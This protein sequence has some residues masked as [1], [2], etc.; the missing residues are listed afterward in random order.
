M[1]QYPGVVTWMESV[2]EYTKEHGYVETVWKRRRYLPG[3]YERNKN[4]FDLA[5]RVAINTVA[6]GT[7]AE[8]MK[9]GMV[10]L[11]RALKKHGLRA[12]MLLQIHDE[13]LIEVPLEEVEKTKQLV[14]HILESVVDWNVPLKVT[15]RTGSDW[16]NVR[17]RSS[18]YQSIEK[19]IK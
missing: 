16:Q 18:N 17:E 11:G 9:L 1:A 7:A 12:E 15:T 3:I 19:R 13:L 8:L 4:L 14:S 5:R 10:N 6:Q 2:I